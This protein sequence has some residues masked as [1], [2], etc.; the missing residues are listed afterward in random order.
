MI[1]S[2]RDAATELASGGELEVKA[3]QQLAR[4]LASRTL[5]HADDRLKRFIGF[6][7]EETLSGY[8]DQ[9]KEF[10][11]GIEVFGKDARF[12]PRADPIVRVQARRLRS[13]PARYYNEEGQFD[14]VLSVTTG[15][16]PPPTYG[17]RL[18]PTPLSR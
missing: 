11:V 16:S 8:G 15:L 10:L 1:I 6:I 9:L 4:I 12:D 18:R 2:A 13:R 3:R 17:P 5:N 7:V 14:E